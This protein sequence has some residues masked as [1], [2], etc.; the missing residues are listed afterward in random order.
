MNST[1]QFV[2][3]MN[4][5]KEHHK[6]GVTHSYPMPLV[7]M[8]GSNLSANEE[9]MSQDTKEVIKNTKT[10]ISNFHKDQAAGV[11]EAIMSLEKS[12]S[13][14]ESPDNMTKEFLKKMEELRKKA[15]D[16][17]NTTIDKMYNKLIEKAKKHPN[18]QKHILSA[19]EK[20]GA[21]ITNILLDIQ[22]FFVEI[23][24]KIVEWFN[25]VVNWFKKA[26]E[27]ISRWVSES[28]RSIENWFVTTFSC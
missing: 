9:P 25:S 10:A 11:E 17:S 8:I 6:S 26:G 5:M 21:F 19:T 16:E 23:G 1:E 2:H 20:L 15:K 13:S 27:E 24:N 28:A 18:Q 3:H 22:K 12:K 14:G 7:L 4:L